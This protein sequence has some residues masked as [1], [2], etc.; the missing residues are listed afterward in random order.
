VSPCSHL[1]T[2]TDPVSE[3]LVL[4]SLLEF[5]KMD[6]VFKPSES[7]KPRLSARTPIKVSSCSHWRANRATPT[8]NWKCS[9]LQQCG[10]VLAVCHGALCFPW[11]NVTCRESQR[12]ISLIGPPPGGSPATF[13][14]ATRHVYS[15]YSAKERSVSSSVCYTASAQMQLTAHKII[16]CGM[17]VGAVH[18]IQWN[19][20]WVHYLRIGISR[21]P[22]WPQ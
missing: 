12:R 21:E 7:Q 2:E 4:S 15:I 16:T 8:Y 22:R 17:T 13:L 3:T 11:W 10:I 18:L 1:K 5:K 20:D 6:K 14:H 19:G 9:T